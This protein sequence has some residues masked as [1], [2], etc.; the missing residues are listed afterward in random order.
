[1]PT[2]TKT[3]LLATAPS[4]AR[5]SVWTVTPVEAKALAEALHDAEPRWRVR[6]DGR[7]PVFSREGRVIDLVPECE[8]A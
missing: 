1:M 8:A 5:I 4:G 7:E 3:E 2:R 6:I